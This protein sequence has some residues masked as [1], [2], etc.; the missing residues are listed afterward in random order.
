ME[1]LRLNQ[2]A[3]KY[4]AIQYALHCKCVVIY[5]LIPEYYI[6]IKNITR[7]NYFYQS[8]ITTD[9]IYFKQILVIQN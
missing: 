2:T 6:S 8:Q 5:N 4:E 9:N 7:P 1:L 3:R